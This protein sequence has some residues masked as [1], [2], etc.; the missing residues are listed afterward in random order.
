MERLV[1]LGRLNIAWYRGS[2]L[3]VCR[4]R[5]PQRMLYHREH[6]RPGCNAL[7]LRCA[8]SVCASYKI[9]LPG[10]S[11][12]AQL[13]TPATATRI[14]FIR[15]RLPFAASLVQCKILYIKDY[16]QVKDIHAVVSSCHSSFHHL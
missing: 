11:E 13:P 5:M 14:S 6:S 15:G 7:T 12:L 1:Q 4:Y 10:P 2:R 8:L 3:F 9:R 16:R